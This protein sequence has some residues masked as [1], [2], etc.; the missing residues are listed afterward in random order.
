MKRSTLV[1]LKIPMPVTI[2]ITKETFMKTFIKCCGLALALSGTT[3]LLAADAKENYTK[4]CAKCH[5]ADGKGQTKMGK[6]SGAKDYTDPKVQAEMDDTRAAKQIKEGMKE[7][8][9]EK[10]KAYAEKFSDDEIKALI[11]H[12]RTFKK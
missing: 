8:G 4:E 10:M 11:A 1:E 6:Q 9:K 12:M 2:F 7:N 3:S 5:G